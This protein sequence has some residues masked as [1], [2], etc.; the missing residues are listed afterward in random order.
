M[1]IYLTF[2]TL[3]ITL[4]PYHLITCLYSEG[5]MLELPQPK[6]KGTV[7]LEE[8]II[9]RRSVR[10]FQNKT[11]AIEQ[12]SQILWSAQGITSKRGFR[13]TPSA[14]AIYPMEI[15]LVSTD[16][17]FHYIPQGHKILK[18]KDGDLRMQLCNAAYGQEFI[19]DAGI[20][21]IIACDYEKIKLRYRD[22]ATRYADME[23]GHITQN[24]QLQAVS[25]GLGSCP[26]G[27]FNDGSVSKLLQLPK[28][29]TP[30]YII[31]VGYIK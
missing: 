25:L 1:K 21:I 30:I 11:L 7:S 9:K 19:A 17:L 8:A 4:S 29:L 23:A 12:I 20:S 13:S 5:K 24:I 27:A 2:L 18:L 14:G 15:Y 28:N 22:R 3:L 16:G 31:P 10:N 6:T 26:V